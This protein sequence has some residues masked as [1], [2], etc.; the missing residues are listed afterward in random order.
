MD[1]L[2]LYLLKVTAGTTL[3][4]ISYLLLF[5]KD[6]FYLRNRIFLI[7]TLLMPT[8]F[9]ALKISIFSNTVTPATPV[10]GMQNIIF[11]ESPYESPIT[12]TIN[13]FDYNNLFIWIYFTI[14]GLL[15]LRIIVSLISTY[16]IITKGS[17]KN[18][19]FPN[20]IV[21]ENK[22][23][24]FSFYP[25]TV[26]PVE[27]Y[28]S[29][30][31]ID[32]LDHEFAHIKQGHTFDLLLSEL[33]IAF[34]WFNPFV[35]FIKRSIILNH[36]YLADHV[37]VKNKS[38]KEYQY[39]L[40]NFQTGLKHI[41]LAHNFNNLIKNRIIMINKKPTK[42]YA[43][44]KNFLILPVVAFVAY[45]F[46]TPAYKYS[47]A[48][49]I[50]TINS[51]N[52]ILNFSQYVVKGV[53]FKDDG[54]PL[55]GVKVISTTTPEE[56]FSVKTGPDGRFTLEVMNENESILFFCRGYKQLILKPKFKV[57]MRVKMETD[58]TYK[59]QVGESASK[60][61]AIQ[62]SAPIVAIDGIISEKNVFDAINDLGYDKGTVK[63]ING[64]EATDK[65]GEKG[66][67][68]VYEITTRKKAIAMGLKPPFPRL[69]PDDYPTFQNIRH[70]GFTDWVVKQAK[71]P[72]E[73]KSKKL[74][75]WVTVDFKIELDGQISN[76]IGMSGFVD[77]ILVSEVKR[78]ILSSPKWDSP[79]NKAVDEPFSTNITLRFKLP[80]QII[81]VVPLVI[82]DQMPQY[83][84]GDVELLKFIGK[85]AKY[86]EAAKKDKIEGRVIL[87][88]IVTTEG[89]AEGISILKSVDPKLDTEAVRV[90][91]MLSGFQP[92]LQGGMPVNVWYVVPVTFSLPASETL[93]K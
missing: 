14:T 52:S 74:E 88:F 10:I 76:V 11:P 47:D 3:F 8:I 1:N 57:E 27:E 9:P 38:V 44:L 58:S 73:A 63:M 55:E 45:A 65:Y 46:A 64:K 37:S 42:K 69:T 34:Q 5:R 12:N 43:M 2:F 29:G 81:G 33:F 66:G 68:G 83:P 20:V 35:W 56:A 4:Y 92:G 21:S 22:L 54:K 75:G 51:T 67:N 36:E 28:K 62:R 24:P 39:R 31:Y 25:Y 89:K 77:P 87:R 85:N 60:N 13:S 7:L 80:D 17:V 70:T 71:Y 82:T 48:P 50:Q 78:I 18:D 15:M 84:G 53:V 72:A 16:R 93:N 61:P 49:L 59:V 32:L 41:L 26:I 90:V 23:P 6:T 19:Q 91:S 86:P 79:K 40:L 30:N